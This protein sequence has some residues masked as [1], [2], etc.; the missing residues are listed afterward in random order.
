[1]KRILIALFFACGSANAQYISGQEYVTWVDARDRANAG[2]ATG[3]DSFLKDKVMP[4]TLGVV[5]VSDGTYF[6]IPD[7]VLAGQVEAIATKYVKA[8]PE[9]WNSPA[10]HL[11]VRA[12]QNV[13]PCKKK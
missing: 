6:C 13:F 12:L 4:F 3:I 1:M 10:A 8:N 11:I 2:Q 7:G 9:S 5:D